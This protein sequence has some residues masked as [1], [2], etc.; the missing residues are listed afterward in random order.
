MTEYKRRPHFICV[1]SVGLIGDAIQCKQKKTTSGI[2]KASPNRGS[3]SPNAGEIGHGVTRR[4]STSLSRTVSSEKEH[5]PNTGV[6][7]NN[8]QSENGDTPDR[9]WS[10]D[11][12]RINTRGRHI[13]I[14]SSATGHRGH[15]SRVKDDQRTTLAPVIPQPGDS[16]DPP[17]PRMMTTERTTEP[18]MMWGS[19]LSR[20]GLNVSELM[21]R[22][23]GGPPA[24]PHAALQELEL[25]AVPRPGQTVMSEHNYHP[26][27]RHLRP[28]PPDVPGH[29]P[30]VA[31]PPTADRTHLE[32]RDSGDFQKKLPP[33][34]KHDV[35]SLGRPGVTSKPTE[36]SL[37]VPAVVHKSANRTSIKPQ[38]E[39]T[40]RHAAS[41]P[42]KEQ[43]TE[44]KTTSEP[45]ATDTTKFYIANET[46][47]TQNVTPSQKATLSTKNMD[48]HNGTGKPRKM[49]TTSSTTMS[50]STTG[51]SSVRMDTSSVTPTTANAMSNAT[52]EPKNITKQNTG[53][54]AFSG[55][56]EEEEI[57]SESSRNITLG[58]VPSESPNVMTSVPGEDEY[59]RQATAQ[60]LEEQQA[61]EREWL[62]HQES[63]S[64]T[65]R[66]Q[67]SKPTTTT[68]KQN[69]R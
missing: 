52:S 24:V 41:I 53:N 67:G 34:A 33:P 16:G 22:L 8:D 29:P 25:P 61:A 21:R 66:H 36:I 44:Q 58:T 17:Y 6:S 65:V 7:T 46:S 27:M 69:D 38:Y 42:H 56:E 62:Q 30:W 68:Q 51:R 20:R 5:L 19:L 31:Q 13:P 55:S 59:D 63:T 57:Q 18:I 37:R 23:G 48:V 9:Q 10:F 60:T 40:T 64:I 45:P 32:H 35:E 15:K 39:A 43:P 50:S 11:F 26:I 3:E 14:Q 28:L 4:P 47:S 12:K 54:I 1:P 49:S 2:K